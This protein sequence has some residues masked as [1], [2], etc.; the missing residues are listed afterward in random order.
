MSDTPR[1]DDM[2]VTKPP[3]SDDYYDLL[4][5][6]RELERDL[7]RVSR[8]GSHLDDLLQCVKVDL[9]TAWQNYGKLVAIYARDM[10]DGLI[11][12]SSL[13]NV[14]KDA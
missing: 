11:N 13:P 3:L 5:L 10:N 2:E 9:D 7:A 4:R 14:K 6:A 1:C 8:T 12:K